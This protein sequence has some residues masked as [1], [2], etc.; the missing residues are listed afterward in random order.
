MG[1]A[2][3]QLGAGGQMQAMEQQLLNQQLQ[4]FINQ[5]QMP[6]KQAEFGMGIL[7]GIP[8]TGQTSTLYQQ[9]GS[10][11]GQIVGAGLGI[12]GLFGGLGSTTG[13]K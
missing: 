8:A 12:G 5:Q 3:T 4:D 6:Y 1:I 7:R 13:S 10:L 11:F 2:S 9:P